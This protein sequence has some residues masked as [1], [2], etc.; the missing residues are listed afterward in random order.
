M[1]TLA[2]AMIL[3]SLN[4]GPARA[5][6]V[7]A[8]SDQQIDLHAAVQVGRGRKCVLFTDAA[9]V[10]TRCKVKPWPRSAAVRWYKVEADSAA[11]NNVPQGKFSFASIAW[12]RSPWTGRAATR[13]ADVQAVRRRGLSGVGT[14]RYQI[15]VRWMQGEL[16]AS[17][18]LRSRAGGP[19]RREDIRKVSVRSGDGYLDYMAELAGLPYVFGSAAQ[20]S[21]P[22]QAE[23]RIGV[24]CADLMIYGLRRLGHQV[25]Y[26]S[27]RTLGPVSRRIVSQVHERKGTMYLHKGRTI[28][29]GAQG[30]QPGDWLIFEGHVGAFVEDRGQL[31]ML[32][33]DDLLIHIAWKEVA[34]ET[35]ANSGY[36]ASAFEIRRPKAL[37]QAGS[38]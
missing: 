38:N 31:G 14:M 12:Q 15:E 23:R 9:R 18:G 27:S 35:L 1:S 10:K 13:R 30:V 29:V 5:R 11:Y 26:R 34:V 20:G 22:H 8:R 2:V 33:T 4:A 3:T 7:L 16:L 37:A 36:G 25:A 19:Q 21:E 28:A 32:D 24:D 17:P 6:D